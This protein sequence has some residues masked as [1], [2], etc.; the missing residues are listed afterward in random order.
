MRKMRR[1]RII[2]LVRMFSYIIT[3]RCTEKTRRFTEV[4]FYSFCL[5]FRNCISNNKI[6]KINGK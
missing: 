3:Q 5:I 1:T 6:P 2:L 4:F